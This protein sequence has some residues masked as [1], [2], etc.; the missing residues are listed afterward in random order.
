M[1]V[2]VT[3][4]LDPD[5]LP[6]LE[7]AT[8]CRV[9]WFAETDLRALKQAMPMDAL[10]GQSPSMARKEVWTHLLAYNLLAELAQAAGRLPWRL[11]L[12]GAVQKATAF[13]A[14]LWAATEE[15]LEELYS[16][17]L[18]AILRRRVGDRPNRCEPRA[19]KRRPK[20]FPVLTE[21]RQKA[22]ARL[23]ARRCG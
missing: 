17:L 7:A 18:L 12:K 5:E 3:T 16:R 19:R 11:S 20:K 23:A 1:L 13:A 4:V 8:L 9:R 21:L 6:R 22:K 15:E 2:V 10:R 14:A